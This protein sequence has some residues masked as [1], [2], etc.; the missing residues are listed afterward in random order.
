MDRFFLMEM[1]AKFSIDSQRKLDELNKDYWQQDEIERSR[2]DLEKTGAIGG[3]ARSDGALGIL[4]D[5]HLDDRDTAEVPFDDQLV[6]SDIIEAVRRATSDEHDTG[7]WDYIKRGGALN[8][9]AWL[10]YEARRA[11]LYAKPDDDLT[12][13]DWKQMHALDCALV[14]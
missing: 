8:Y 4:V 14:Y 3:L 10:N 5:L 6:E 12:D 13:A 7:Y 1:H 2:R 9:K 11:A